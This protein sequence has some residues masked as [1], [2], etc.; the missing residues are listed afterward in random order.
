[1]AD[2]CG[3]AAEPTLVELAREASPDLVT[4][5][6]WRVAFQPGTGIC[7]WTGPHGQTL[8]TH[9]PPT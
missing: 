5:G 8:R 2:G 3:R 7:T 6:G 4:T 1:V 9:P